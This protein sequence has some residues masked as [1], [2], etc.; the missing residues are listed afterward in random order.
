M[1]SDSPYISTSFYTLLAYQR[2]SYTS[3]GI[4]I[5]SISPFYR[6]ISTMD[7]CLA[8]H[9]RDLRLL[10]W[11]LFYAN[12]HKNRVFSEKVYSYSSMEHQTTAHLLHHI[13]Y[14][15]KAHQIPSHRWSLAH[16]TLI[17]N[18]FTANSFSTMQ[19]LMIAHQCLLLPA[20]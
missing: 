18:S 5:S 12:I 4:D 19:A 16:P 13:I 14:R 7:R 17:Y 2:G 1:E 20:D 15:H 10:S 3:T 6:Q 9:L 11:C 8:A